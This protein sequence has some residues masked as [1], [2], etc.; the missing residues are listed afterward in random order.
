MS[1][2]IIKR[3]CLCVFSRFNP[4]DIV[5]RHYLTGDSF[6]LHSF[7]HRSYWFHGKHREAETMRMFAR[8]IS[9]HNCVFDIGGHIGYVARYLSSLVSRKGHVYVFEPAPN[10]LQYLRK[11]VENYPTITLIPK[12]VGIADGRE[13]MYIESLTGQNCS[14]IKDYVIQRNAER[15]GMAGPKVYETEVE[16]VALDH[17][18][19]NENVTPDFLKIDAEGF[20][21]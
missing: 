14:L 20:E 5:V 13:K 19:N 2:G 21:W 11:N 1:I 8:L 9:P 4:G 3:A 7:Y 15:A 17:F 6:H 16:V 12:A 18:A 10:N